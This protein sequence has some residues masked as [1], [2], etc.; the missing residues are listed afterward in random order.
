MEGDRMRIPDA[1]HP[2]EK[3]CREAGIM[4][5]EEYAEFVDRLHRTRLPA[6]MKDKEDVVLTR[7]KRGNGAQFLANE[8][9]KLIDR[10]NDNPGSLVQWNIE[11]DPMHYT[12]RLLRY[13]VT[14]DTGTEKI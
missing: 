11:L 14:I 9:R 6:D 12:P 8:M 13:W 7:T 4:E 10:L 3:A 1:Q 2:L 5:G